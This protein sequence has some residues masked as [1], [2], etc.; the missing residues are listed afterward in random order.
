MTF[1]HMITCIWSFMVVTVSRYCAHK[2]YRSLV[3]LTFYGALRGYTYLLEGL[4]ATARCFQSQ[5]P[6]LSANHWISFLNSYSS[7]HPIYIRIHTLLEAFI[8]QCI[9]YIDVPYGFS[10]SGSLPFNA[11]ICPHFGL[12]TRTANCTAGNNSI[13]HTSRAETPPTPRK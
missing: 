12:N 5:K 13:C 11:F 10:W 1:Y 6:P 9:R 2:L 8:N 3:V 7:Q 4:D